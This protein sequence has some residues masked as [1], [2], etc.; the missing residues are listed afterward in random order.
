MRR[1]L[2]LVNQE[3][4]MAAMQDHADGTVGKALSVLDLVAQAGRPVRL[5]ELAAQCP[6]P[7]ATLHRLLQTLTHQGMLMRQ[8]TTG[9]YAPGLRLVRLAH[10]A[11]AQSDLATVARPHLDRLAA[12]TGGTIHLAQ[13][14]QGQVLYLDKRNAAQPLDLFSAAG[15][16][17]PAYCTGVGKA[18]LAHLPP[19]GLEEAMMRQSF[20]RFTS[21]TIT[22]AGALRA[23]LEE[24]RSA[25]HAYD[26]EEHEPGILCCAVPVL[27]GRARAMA[28]LSLT[29]SRRDTSLSALKL[30]L[31]LL[32]QAAQAIAA[33]AAVWRFP[34]ADD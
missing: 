33:E 31:P 14:D 3:A 6:F 5:A 25:G 23:E 16:I 17:G 1:S 19:A 13:L 28:A 34:V 2:R 10:A 26:R 4:A 20:H 22:T 32:K 11:W 8:E 7:K 27:D 29:G 15:K 12:E 9:A 30:H 21:A 18:M 24:I